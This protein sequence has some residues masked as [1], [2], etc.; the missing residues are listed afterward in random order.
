MPISF[1]C[2][3]CGA[4]TNVADQYAGQTGPCAQCNKPIDLEFGDLGWSP[5]EDATEYR[6]PIMENGAGFFVWYN[7]KKGIAYQRAN[8]W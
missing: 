7:P 6:G 4:Q 8:Y 5:L 2:P 1:T 3:H